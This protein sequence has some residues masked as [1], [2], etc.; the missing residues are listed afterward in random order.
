MNV[1]AETWRSAEPWTRRND[2]AQAL[3]GAEID[4]DLLQALLESVQSADAISANAALDILSDRPLSEAAW[5]PLCATVR[6]QR[7]HALPDVDAALAV[8]EH[9]PDGCFAT[10]A[11]TA[12]R[13][14]PE[15][16]DD[17]LQC[18]A[19]LGRFSDDR[20]PGWLAAVIDSGA[21]S[22]P[23]LTA[24]N[25][26][27]VA[28]GERLS[29]DKKASFE[30]L[31]RGVLQR[32]GATPADCCDSWIR[33]MAVDCICRLSGRAA[34]PLLAG[35]CLAAGADAP[36]WYPGYLARTTATLFAEPALAIARIDALIAR[37]QAEGVQSVP[38]PALP[39]ATAR[40]LARSPRIG[41]RAVEELGAVVKLSAEAKEAVARRA[42]IERV[43]VHRGQLIASFMQDPTVQL[44][45][46]EG[47]PVDDLGPEWAPWC[48]VLSEAD[49]EQLYGD[50]ERWIAA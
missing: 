16:A 2:L 46:D 32:Q 45:P 42:A 47:E 20:V 4:A 34:L 8:A 7:V 24:L 37:L 43:L 33:W 21:A 18:L 25:H 1:T 50:E 12:F 26:W 15:D 6:S 40:A 10:V 38:L 5:K 3:A 31:L 23:A 28:H 14:G 9:G 17:R 48:D 41:R 36:S 11:L 30:T 22:L 27:L 35:A 19:A 13:A 49:R 39:D 44:D 29:T